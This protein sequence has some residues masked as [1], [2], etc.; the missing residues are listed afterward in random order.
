MSRSSREPTVVG[1]LFDRLGQLVET[2]TDPSATSVEG[3]L[4]PLNAINRLTDEQLR[5][6][7]EH[8]VATLWW[9]A[10]IVA[11]MRGLEE[12]VPGSDLVGRFSALSRH[13]SG[14][15]MAKSHQ[16]L[17]LI[18]DAVSAQD[19][20]LV[21][22]IADHISQGWP[23]YPDSPFPRALVALTKDFPG[24]TLTLSEATNTSYVHWQRGLGLARTGNFGE[25]SK[26]F[27]TASKAY[28]RLSYVSDAAWLYVDRIVCALGTGKPAQ[29]AELR[30]D[31]ITYLDKILETSPPSEED[32]FWSFDDVSDDY[33]TF[34]EVR[35]LGEQPLS[36]RDREI[37][38][39]YVQVS[40]H[41]LRAS[42]TS[43]AE[44]VSAVDVFSFGWRS[45]GQS[46]YPAIFQRLADALEI[47]QFEPSSCYESWL[48]L[49]VLPRV[50]P[51]AEH[52][53]DRFDQLER[54]LIR[55]GLEEEACVAVLDAAVIGYVLFGRATASG[56]LAPRRHRPN[57]LVPELLTAAMKCLQTPM[58]FS[59]EGALSAYLTGRSA[60][61]QPAFTDAII[62][63]ADARRGRTSRNLQVRLT[64]TTFSVSGVIIYSPVPPVV[65][66]LLDL[67]IGEFIETTDRGEFPEPL[68][69][70]V[71]AERLDLSPGAV[72]QA[73]HRLRSALRR[74]FEECLSGPLHDTS[75]L[76]GRPG[77]RINPLYVQG[78]MTTFME[79]GSSGAEY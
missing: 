15:I 16:I 13:F 72:T 4:S 30:D 8:R 54:R 69:S 73:I 33:S 28:E 53:F 50:L 79:E 20:A 77:Y 45:F 65:G 78:A 25:A 63:L 34:V 43:P 32:A 22:A 51:V 56:W 71:L 14:R 37:L 24:P 29:A 66:A 47:S 74:R 26:E 1:D 59:H 49:L 61:T 38:L 23:A 36:E 21:V 42:R 3:E 39:S 44:L 55:A 46:P 7:P 35:H 6:E 19:P 67:L 2:F 64:P 41:L 5:Y 10:A 62:S 57:A 48:D 31:Q 12:Q 68:A 76:Q 17:G 75:V 40:N 27:E 9:L 58:G 52:H 18:D 70:T 11:R 60:T